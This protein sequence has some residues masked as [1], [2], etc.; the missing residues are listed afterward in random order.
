[1]TSALARLQAALADKPFDAVLVS[2][3][4]NQRYLSGFSYSDGYQLITKNAAF[5]F[6][7]PRYAEAARAQVT[8]FIIL[9][10]HMRQ[11]DA[12]AEVIEGNHIGTVAIEENALSYADFGKFS[13]KLPCSLVAGASALLGELRRVKS[14][15]ELAT[16]ARAQEITDRAFS[17]I[18][19]Y[20][21]PLVTEREVAMELEFFMRREGAEA[22]AFS[23]IAVSGTA[24]SLPHGEPRDLPLQKGFL[25][26]DFGAQVNGYC[27]DMTRTVV[28]GRA[29]EEMKRVYETVLGAQRAA[30]DFVR[31]GVRCCD[32]DAAARQYIA[33][34]GYGAYF[35]HSLGHGIGMLVHEAPNFSRL[36]PTDSLLSRGNVMSVEPGIY[37]EGKYGVRIEDMIAVRHDG[38]I[39]NFTQSPKELIE[40]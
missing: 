34:A 4:I 22:T 27:S 23:T 38:T 16:I 12:V 30:L 17:H 9:I 37:I 40:L 18:L 3:E 29:D 5:L 1:M 24:S 36:A 8:D 7:D 14:D 31:E 39:Q 19:N 35:T 20:I 26:M 10:P 13:E 6:T 21:S 32:V 25:T 33:D 2:S 11:L 28:I 15:A